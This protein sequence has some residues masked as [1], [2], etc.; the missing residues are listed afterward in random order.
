M[1]VM[2]ADSFKGCVICTSLYQ[3]L[4]II[5][6]DVTVFY[7]NIRYIVETESTGSTLIFLRLPAVIDAAV[8]YRES[9]GI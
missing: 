8:A 1:V 7:G 5:V 9:D 4:Q 6:M 2:D 3:S